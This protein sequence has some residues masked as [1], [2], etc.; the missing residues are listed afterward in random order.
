[1]TPLDRASLIRTSLDKTPAKHV[2]AT[3]VLRDYL[4]KLAYQSLSDNNLSR[5]GPHLLVSETDLP[6]D[7]KP[8]VRLKV[9]VTRPNLVLI[10]GLI[11]QKW[12]LFQKMGFLFGE[13]KLF[14]YI[15]RKKYG[16]KEKKSS[17]AK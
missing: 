16:R 14:V 10:S 9:H 17:L 2:P 8:F 7:I 12:K 11:T 3:A 15:T 13:R 1:M 5:Y 4:Y 6:S